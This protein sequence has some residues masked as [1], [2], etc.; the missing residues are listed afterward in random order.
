[1]TTPCPTCPICN[2]KGYTVIEMPEGFYDQ[3]NPCACLHPR[4]SGTGRSPEEEE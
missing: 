2:D 3:S 4:K 1:M